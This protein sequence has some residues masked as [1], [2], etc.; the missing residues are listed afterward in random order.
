[1]VDVSHHQQV[2]DLNK[3]AFFSHEPVNGETKIKAAQ[4]TQRIQEVVV[5]SY[6][7]DKTWKDDKFLD[8]LKLWFSS[9]EKLHVQALPLF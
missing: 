8:N 9:N 2:G 4:L 1:M 3:V 7:W 5:K 6:K